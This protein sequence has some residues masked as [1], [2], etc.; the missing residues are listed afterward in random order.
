M[1]LPDE[2]SL[3][4]IVS[5]YAHLRSGH[6]EA[7]GDPAVV[8]PSGVFFPDEFRVDRA[9][10]DRLLRRMVSYAPISDELGIE[11][12]FVEPDDGHAG[13]C[14]S[15]GCGSGAPGAL[16]LHG[17]QE[18]ED[19]Y[20]V[21]LAASAVALPDMLAASL[22]RAVGSLVLYE[23]DE[24]V[25]ARA[26]E[27]AAVACG[28]GVLV[29]NGAAVWAKSCG[30]LKMTRATAL[31]LEEVAVAL[32]LFAAVHDK[33]TSEARRFLRTTQ[34]AAFDE[35]VDWVDSNSAIVEGL[36]QRPVMLETGAFDV[37]PVRGPLG[38]WLRGWHARRA[39][40]LAAPATAPPPI[41]DERRRWLAEAQALV[42][43][44]MTRR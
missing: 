41:T 12:A 22:S 23:A 3:R 35:A 13:G 24:P 11:L 14:G 15:P 34:R 21:F 32:A 18:L 17:V 6:G 7:I 36:R 40:S 9:S 33:T 28:F 25:D 10:V 31:D 38:R 5:S 26:S 30:G 16:P 39:Q 42:D 29:A 1:A 43:E 20:R 27:L 8:Q 44:V 4:W 19:G 2:D 37:E